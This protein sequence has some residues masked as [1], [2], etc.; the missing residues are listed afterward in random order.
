MKYSLLIIFKKLNC[1][2]LNCPN[3]N[4]CAPI[5][6]VLDAKFLLQRFLTWGKFTFRYKFF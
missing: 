3:L 4:F 1:R 2:I 5:Q 6:K